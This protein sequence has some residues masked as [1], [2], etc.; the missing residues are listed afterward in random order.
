MTSVHYQQSSQHAADG[1]WLAA[2][3]EN[4]VLLVES[5]GT[6][7]EVAARLDALWRSLGSAGGIQATLDELTRGGL[8][9]TPPFALVQWEGE[10]ASGAVRAIVRG[11]VTL[12]VHAEDGTSTTADARG[13]STWLEQQ[14]PAVRGFELRVGAAAAAT[15]EA[16]AEV[17]V[18]A[19]ADGASSALPL[20][21]GVVRATRIVADFT[22]LPTPAETPSAHAASVP[23]PVVPAVPVPTPAAT[24]PP[25]AV[26]AAPTVWV[27][28]EA[29]VT[30]LPAMQDA[31]PAVSSPTVPS[32]EVQ[33]A[34]GVAEGSYDYLFG[35]TVFRTVEDAAVRDEGE[36]VPDAPSAA[37]A[38]ADSPGTGD[39]DGH[40]IA[41]AN[42]AKLRAGRKARGTARPP[43]AAPG[44][45]LY[46]ELADGAREPLTQPILVGRVP[47]V[48]KVSGGQIP[49]LLTVA[50]SDQDISRNHAQF[51][52]EGGTVVVTD[53]HSRNGTM[54][55]LPGRSP[56]QLRQGEPTSVIVGTV[57][58]LG[59]G[60]TFTV[61][62]E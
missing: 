44:S 10:P 41:S 28:P 6:A 23:T 40:T 5:S 36:P 7:S 9:A 2:V 18:E 16:T 46:L 31:V 54:I 24:V 50:G 14:Y 25:R 12:T 59:G 34:E 52:V 3:H 57:V 17:A 19:A 56:Q 43:A 32:P 13:V 22:S 27:D 51:A 62:E 39:H 1:A 49:K 45:R 15:A 60:V 35:K 55:V 21:S 53:L 48:N 33:P 30:G 58:D 29:T 20:R 42:I 38:D 8:S 47:S 61:G 11:S 26:P 4:S 37:D